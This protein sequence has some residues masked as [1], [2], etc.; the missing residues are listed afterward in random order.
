M[1]ELQIFAEVSAL[2]NLDYCITQEKEKGRRACQPENVAC[3][4]K[5]FSGSIKMPGKTQA[6]CKACK[7]IREIYVNCKKMCT[8]KNAE[9]KRTDYKARNLVRNSSLNKAAQGN[10]SRSLKNKANKACKNL[11]SVCGAKKIYKENCRNQKYKQ[12]AE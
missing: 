8:V 7:K 1:T 6:A 11:A 5:A 9:H 2:F 3:I 10:Y 12:K 4:K